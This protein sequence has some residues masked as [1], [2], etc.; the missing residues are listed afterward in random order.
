MKTDGT[1]MIFTIPGWV[2]LGTG[3]QVLDGNQNGTLFYSNSNGVEVHLFEVL[4]SREYTY[5]GVVNLS[6]DPYQ[7]DQPDINGAM[8]KVWMFPIKPISGAPVMTAEAFEA[9]QEKKRQQAESMSLSALEKAA[10][11]NSKSRPGTRKVNSTQ[12]V[13]DPYVSEY[14]KCL[15]NGKC[16]L[17]GQPAP[18][19]DSKGKPYLETHHI[20]WLSKGGSDSIDNTV[21]LCPN[22]HRKMHVINDPTD[23]KKL[24][25]VAASRS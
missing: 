18:F 1:G 24:Q 10:K 2:K 5:R 16:E 17:C 12:I 3:D 14:T 21:G 15:A 22:C 7:E 8:R 13:R 9:V 20:K 25:D 19:K 6:G 23:V 11:A 4:D